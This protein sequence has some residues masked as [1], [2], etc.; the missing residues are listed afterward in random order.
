MP[1]LNPLQRR[2]LE[3]KNPSQTLPR[4]GGLKELVYR[5]LFL[6]HVAGFD[7]GQ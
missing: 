5:G 3:K 2:G 7:H 6:L 1:P 4:N